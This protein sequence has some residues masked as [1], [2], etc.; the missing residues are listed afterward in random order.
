[1]ALLAAL[2]RVLLQFIVP[3]GSMGNAIRGGL[4][5]STASSI[6]II[7]RHNVGGSGGALAT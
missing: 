6:S 3:V 1:M 7:A 2:G 5:S 4:W